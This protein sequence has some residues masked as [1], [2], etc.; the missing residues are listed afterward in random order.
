[1][2][3]TFHAAP[4]SSTHDVPHVHESPPSMLVPL[5]VLA[6]CSILAGYVGVPSV[7]GGHNA[8]EHFLRQAATE[9]TAD[10]LGSSTTEGILMAVSTGASLLGLALAYVFY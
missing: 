7:L 2:S 8:L 3:L 5:V 4:R 6:I 9:I 1:V 10:T